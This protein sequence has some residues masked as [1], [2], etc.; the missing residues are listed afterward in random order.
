MNKWDLLVYGSTNE[1]GEHIP[2]LIEIAQDRYA[3]D[4]L[5]IRLI[6]GIIIR[7]A[8]DYDLEF[9]E[10]WQFKAY[11]KSIRCCPVQTKSIIETMWELS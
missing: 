7:A 11:C 6:I 3:E 2:G 4:V 8:E 10:S 1:Y 5:E 9:F